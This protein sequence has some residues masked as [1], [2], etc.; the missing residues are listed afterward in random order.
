MKFEFLDANYNECPP[1]K[2]PTR[3]GFEC[4]KRTNGFMC[5][6]LIIRNNPDGL[7]VQ[8]QTWEW[9]GDREKPTFSPSINCANCSH[10]YIENGVWRDA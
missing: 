10:G 8:N 2:Q 7:H 6:G 5:T 9:N 4:P 3:F 1:D